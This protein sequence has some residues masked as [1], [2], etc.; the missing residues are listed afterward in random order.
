[1]AKLSDSVGVILKFSEVESHNSLGAGERY[2]APLRRIY[3][4]IRHESPQLD[5]RLALRL[6]NKVMNDSIGS[7]GLVPSL[8]VFG[9]VPRMPFINS[10]LPGQIDRIMRAVQAACREMATI[11]VELRIRKSLCSKTP[12]AAGYVLAAEDFVRVSH[13]S[14]RKL[15]GPYRVKKLDG[16]QIFINRNGTQVQHNIAQVVPERVFNGDETLRVLRNQLTKAVLSVFTNQLASDI[17]LTC[18]VDIGCASA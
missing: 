16:K 2:H 11:T 3:L 14:D 6:A 4:K 12:P 5:H 13:E 15:L 9:Y 1:M 18:N 7:E 17:H 10:K 8:L